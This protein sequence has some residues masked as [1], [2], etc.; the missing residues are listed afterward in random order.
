MSSHVSKAFKKALDGS[1]G[2]FATGVHDGLDGN[3][4]LFINPPVDLNVLDTAIFA[5]QS[6]YGQSVM[7][8]TVFRYTDFSQ[9][10]PDAVP[11]NT[12]P[13][14]QH[15][16][17]REPYHHHH[18]CVPDPSAN[19]LGVAISQEN[20]QRDDARTDD[21][22]KQLDYRVFEGVRVIGTDGDCDRNNPGINRH[23]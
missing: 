2:G 4:A 13:D 23:W 7:L 22:G 10:R 8:E 5:Y 20:G 19:P 6:A 3:P 9:Q 15:H 17:R 18:A 12:H 11:S 16:E 14:A 21:S 1:L